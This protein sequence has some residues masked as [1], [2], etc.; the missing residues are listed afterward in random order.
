MDYKNKG[1]SE[2]KA[3]KYTQSSFDRGTDVDD[4]KDA[5]EFNK[6]FYKTKYNELLTKNKEENERRETEAK[7]RKQA[8]KKS[9]LEDKDGFGGIEV[10]DTIRKKV[11]ETINKPVGK[12]KDGD[13]ISALQ[14]YADENPDDFTKYLSYFFVITDGFKNLGN[15]EKS[16]EEKASKKQMKAFEQAINTTLRN[17]DGSLKF[18]SGFSQENKDNNWQLD[19]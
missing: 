18:V 3:L 19:L 12:N 16:S 1:F 8:L 9:I 14:K 5:L 11:Y 7:S 17:P 6:E 4:A 15:I 2:E 10:P 13:P